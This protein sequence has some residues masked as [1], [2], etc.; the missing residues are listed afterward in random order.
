MRGHVSDDRMVDL[1]EDRGIARPTGP[2]S[3]LVRSAGRS[4]SEARAAVGLATRTDV[5]EPPGLYWEALR[6]NVSRRIA[7]EPP[8]RSPVEL[9]AAGGGGGGGAARHR[10]VPRRADLRSRPADAAAR[11]GPRSLRWRRTTASWW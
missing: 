9:G 10:G 4:W 8:A 5:P 3:P 6:R 11:H 1:L 7:E 2:T